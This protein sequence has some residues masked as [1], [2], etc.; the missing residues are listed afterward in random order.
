[1]KPLKLYV[2]EGALASWSGGL[3]VALAPDL[4]QAKIAVRKAHG[5]DSY[6]QLESDLKQPPKIY[7]ATAGAPAVA[8]TIWGSD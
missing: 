4:R 6:G 5:S 8:F 2:W 1:M 3:V 7:P